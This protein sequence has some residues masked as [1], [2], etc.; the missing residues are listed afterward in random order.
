M[1]A[2]WLIAAVA[3]TLVLWRVIGVA[4]ETVIALGTVQALVME[5]AD[6]VAFVSEYPG[7]PDLVMKQTYDRP[8][9]P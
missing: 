5:T 8:G 9:R 1:T 6:Y 4:G 7:V 3:V 2:W